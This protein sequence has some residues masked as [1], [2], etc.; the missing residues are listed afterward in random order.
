M[1]GHPLNLQYAGDPQILTQALAAQGWQAADTLSFENALRLLSPSLPLM[2]L[3]LIPH[4]HDGHHEA[5]GLVKQEGEE[6]RRVLRLWATPYFIDGRQ[7]LWVGNVT[8]QHKR[9]ILNLLAIPATG[10]DPT[11]ALTATVPDLAA[12]NPQRPAADGP[13]LLEGMD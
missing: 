1:N 7:P 2:E 8:D 9:I 10:K 12:L 3:P 13:W 5:L 11:A 4:V 6:G